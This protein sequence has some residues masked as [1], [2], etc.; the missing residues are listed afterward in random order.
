MTFCVSGT[1]ASPRSAIRGEV[2][3]LQYSECE[4]YL[5]A[6]ASAVFHFVEATVV[7]E[8]HGKNVPWPG[9]GFLRMQLGHA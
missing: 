3:I 8:A 9:P 2:R 1:T 7:G 4:R 5:N 6:S